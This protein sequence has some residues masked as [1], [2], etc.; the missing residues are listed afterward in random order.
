MVDEPLIFVEVALTKEIPGAIGP[1]LSRERT[2]LDPSEA[3]TA[4]FYSISNTQRGLTGVTFGSFLIKQVVEEISRELPNLTTFVTL[5]PVP[6]FMEWLAEERAKPD[7]KSI[8][9][10]DRAALAYLDEPKWHEDARR[11]GELTPVLGALAAYYFLA[12]RTKHGRP[13]DPVA[14]FHLGNGARL[15][16]INPMADLSQKA[17]AQSAGVMVNYQYVLADIE[18]NHEAYAEANEV[19]ASTAVK[20]MLRSEKATRALA[21]QT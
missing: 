6:G 21:T 1:V 16:R 7:S 2:L 12:A 15:E 13:I 4:A 5:S 18:K 9:P 19:V 14:R 20:R 10:E 11:A 8:A 3:T 17:I